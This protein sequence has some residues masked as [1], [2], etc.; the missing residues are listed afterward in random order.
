M[1]SLSE[2]EKNQLRLLEEQL[3]AD[4]P[5]FVKSMR[6][7][8][9]TSLGH[10][11]A[12]KRGIL[13]TATG[14]PLGSA[15]LAVGIAMQN[16]GIGALGFVVMVISAYSIRVPRKSSPTSFVSQPKTQSTF[17]ENL[18]RKWDERKKNEI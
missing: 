16:V 17:M 11:S 9:A 1:A 12:K 18:E 4:D 2:H 3:H 14:L 13:F 5:K 7:M 15:I 8:G 6:S 10:S